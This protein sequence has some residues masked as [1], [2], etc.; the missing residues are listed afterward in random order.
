MGELHTLDK[1][2]KPSPLDE[3]GRPTTSS[4][5]SG[6]PHHEST[7]N[8][9]F[10]GCGEAFYRRH[11]QHCGINSSRSVLTNKSF[12][13]SDEGFQ[14]LLLTRPAAIR[15]SQPIM[16]MASNHRQDPSNKS[17]QSVVTNKL[18]CNGDEGFRAPPAPVPRQQ[19]PVQ[20]TVTNTTILSCTVIE[21]DGRLAGLLV[22]TLAVAA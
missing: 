12:W 13:N 2:C 17:N 16:T 11:R 9:P 20:Y 22:R 19:V 5:P 7:A 10:L 18:F 8:K 4:S 1:E 6:P 3:Q 15:P 21:I 14:P